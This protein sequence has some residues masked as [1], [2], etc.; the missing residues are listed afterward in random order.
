MNLCSLQECQFSDANSGEDAIEVRPRGKG[1]DG[2]QGADRKDVGWLGAYS[3]LVLKK[4][5]TNNNVYSN[6]KGSSEFRDQ[7]SVS[8][9]LFM[10]IITYVIFK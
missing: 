1:T 5:G 9:F 2:G 10:Y 4:E 7:Q 3:P 8:H 6:G